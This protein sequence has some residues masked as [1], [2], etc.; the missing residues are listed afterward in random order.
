MQQAAS[1]LEAL[2][3][4]VAHDAEDDAEDEKDNPPSVAQQGAEAEAARAALRVRASQGEIDRLQEQIKDVE[5]R[6]GRTPRVSEQLESLEREHEHLSRSYQ[7]FSNK[8]LEAF[9][10]ANMERSQKG[11]QFR[12][13]EAAYPPVDH[14][15]PNR[16][17][18]IAMGVI[19][20]LL[21]GGAIALGLEFS[22]SSFGTARKLQSSLRIPVL[23]AV[24]SVVF[25]SDRALARRR[26]LRRALAAVAVTGLVV[27]ASVLGN[28]SVNGTPGAIKDLFG[29]GAAQAPAAAE[30]ES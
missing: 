28:W 4:Q 5:E 18:I 11:E 17:L 15:S 27:A 22:D 20:G 8:R 30:Q 24:P 9:V 26:N 7:D 14:V 16:V 6:I 19:L 3:A 2:R 21:L 25:A 10:A 13:L 29:G 23:A 12:V 1:E